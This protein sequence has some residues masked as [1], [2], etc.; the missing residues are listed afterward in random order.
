M[1]WWNGRLPEVMYE[2][3]MQGRWLQHFGAEEYIAQL[4]VQH[5]FLEFGILGVVWFKTPN[6]HCPCIPRPKKS[7]T[8]FD[9]KKLNTCTIRLQVIPERSKGD[10]MEESPEV[11]P[12]EAPSYQLQPPVPSQH[13]WLVADHP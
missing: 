9:I 11:T 1:T 7:H 2:E 13:G 5:G 4:C 8:T 12:G 10:S 3:L 6:R